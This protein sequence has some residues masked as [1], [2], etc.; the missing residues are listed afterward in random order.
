MTFLPDGWRR[1]FRVWRRAPALEVDAEL[2]FHLDERI[3]D[4]LATG[5]SPDSARAQALAEFGDVA[6]VRAGLVAIDT[7]LVGRR[8]RA[9]RWEWV[10]KDLRYVMRSLRR[11]PGFVVMVVLTL[12]LGLGV[13][14][15]I[16]SVLD[17]LFLRTPP[18]IAHAGEV[19]RI[20]RLDPPR[21]SA[22]LHSLTAVTPPEVSTRRHFAYPEVR[23]LIAA[24]PSGTPVAGYFA[25]HE[26]LD[27]G[28][29]AIDI[30]AA[31]VVGSYF[32]LLGVR[33]A[34][35]R[36]F[37]ADEARIETLNPVAVI[38][39]RL[40][41][42]RFEGRRDIV[43][44][45]IDVAYHRY[46]VIGVAAAEF[47]GVD[48][49]AVDVWLPMSAMQLSP[50]G[51]TQEWYDDR[52]TM[53]I[54][55]LTRAGVGDVPVIRHAATLAF[56]QSTI[57]RD[58]SASAAVAPL[59]AA[60]RMDANDRDVAITT[61][62]AGVAL[63][64]LLIAC[65]NVANL[66][67][68]RG[69]RRRREIA[70]RLAL[71]ISR[72]R[73]IATLIAEA[74]V[75]S[76]TGAVVALVVAVWG[77]TAL[78]RMLLPDV[79]W[80]DAAVDMHVLAFTTGLAVVTGLVAG[81]VPAL[82]SSRPDL[83]GTLKGGA[84][85]GQFQRSRV[86]TTLLVAQAALAV[87]L[88]AGAGLFVRSLRSVETA[89]IGYDVNR[90]VFAHV[91]A[92]PDHGD[93]QKE[94]DLRIP[95]LAA[96]LARIG[97]VE[98]VG[99]ASQVPMYGLGFTT[100]SLPGRDSLPHVLAEGPFV[101]Y[102]SPDFFGTVGMHVLRGRGLNSADRAED[103][104]A[105]VVNETMA[106]S[107]WPGQ[108]A[109]GQCIHLEEHGAQCTTV[110]GVVSDAH[111]EGIV[112]K[113]GMQFYLPPGAPGQR[114]GATVIVLRTAPGETPFVVERIGQVLRAEFSGWAE[115]RVHRMNDYL[116]NELR[117]WRTG[118]AL[119]SAAGLLALLVAIVGVYSTISYTFSQRTHEIGVRM[120]LGA[121]AGSV[122]RLVVSEGVRVVLVGVVIGVLLALAAGRLVESMLYH[123]S[124]HDPAVL[125]TVPA[126]LLLAAVCAC[127]IPA[128]RALRVDPAAALRAE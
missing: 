34:L 52:H 49:D 58:S 17:R 15:A 14:A 79:R 118:A 48:N 84:R 10:D 104:L 109:V 55:L 113:P 77:A 93:R 94:I 22:A 51:G 62:L 112:E 41:M 21:S 115:P 6:S 78:R 24:L 75:V 96:R 100:I 43:G 18:G 54:N 122:V 60:S 114:W 44:Q 102:V 123:T 31:F 88:L 20:Y 13:N 30:G 63:I 125:I 64:I 37:T 91:T 38:G 46:V 68:A 2:R 33:P 76:L 45:S 23:E 36:L 73:L 1:V 12:A 47:H 120:A 101:S 103:G 39:Y 72:R 19:H 117:P 25:D 86:R 61:R 116:A 4:L 111:F 65:A 69:M 50:R 71:G 99:L 126:V 59:I 35:G 29:G 74:L 9:E 81:L 105:V 5:L 11:S 128:W 27:R 66:L 8:S 110:V 92:D 85:E 87:L 107:Y 56:S 127:L 42:T 83:A 16:F 82:R 108:A 67:L 80:V 28:D 3:A 97:G 121:R 90:V 7:R 98:Q 95:E 124:S 53:F 26:K 70:V 32:P 119:F 89:D 40:W 106:R 57:I